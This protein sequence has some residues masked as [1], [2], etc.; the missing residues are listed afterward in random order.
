MR[1]LSI[2]LVSL[3]L[4]VAL[5]A[6]AFLWLDQPLSYFAH[7]QLAQYRVF[8][9]MQRTPEF[10]VVFACLIFALVG[11]FVLVRQP[12]NKLMSALLLS[13]VSLAVA[14]QI[15]DQLKFVFGRTWPETWVNNNPSLIRDGVSG[16][17]FFHGG[18]G[19]SSFPSGHTAVTCAVVAVF[20]LSYPRYRPLYAAIVAVVAIGL[21]GANYH[22]LS[23]L[24]AGGLIGWLTGWIAVLLWDAGGLPRLAPDKSRA[25][26]SP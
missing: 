10:M 21:I 6:I 26:P 13:G 7:D 2:F 4:T 5:V 25:G 23:D 18:A 15:K 17:N 9:D 14:T 3:L 1:N 11:F 12:L 22:F 20:W 16:F 19:Y 8:K 24:I